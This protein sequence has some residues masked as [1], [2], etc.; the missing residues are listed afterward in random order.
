MGRGIAVVEHKV[1]TH[2]I[3]CEHDDPNDGFG[4]R[5]VC[6]YCVPTWKTGKRGT[7]AKRLPRCKL[8]HEWLEK[9]GF[10]TLRCAACKKA[11]GEEE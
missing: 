3:T 10:L 9:D 2:P 1:S 7:S 6:F 8:F 5:S 11:C 4:E